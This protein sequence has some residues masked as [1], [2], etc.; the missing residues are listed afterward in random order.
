MVPSLIADAGETA[1]RRYLEFFAVTI[2]NRN[3]RAAYS[4][5]CERFYAW[6]SD[7]RLRLES[8]EPMHVAAY[9]EHHPGSAPTIKQHL[10]AIKMLCDWLVTGHVLPYSPAA[11][12]R[13][14]S[15]VVKSK[16]PTISMSRATLGGWRVFQEGAC[17]QRAGVRAATV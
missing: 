11:S 9:I 14:P 4:R 3:T 16:R 10:A 7:Q 13:G 6:C 17:F 2:R 1:A 15:H 5:A 8:I 12:V